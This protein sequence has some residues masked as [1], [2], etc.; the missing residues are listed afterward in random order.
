MCASLFCLSLCIEWTWGVPLLCLSSLGAERVFLLQDK[1]S[2]SDWLTSVGWEEYPH[3]PV[4]SNAHY[5]SGSILF[6]LFT[7]A[8]VGFEFR[9]LLFLD[10]SSITRARNQPQSWSCSVGSSCELSVD[11]ASASLHH[12]SFSD[13]AT[14]M[15]KCLISINNR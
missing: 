14:K 12:V 1:G 9:S 11:L 4:G 6:Y 8:V 2:A 15:Q 7:L 5:W 13:S 3:L 10:R